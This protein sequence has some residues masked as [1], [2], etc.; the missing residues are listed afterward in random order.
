M[1]F[2][3]MTLRD[4]FAAKAM[5]AMVQATEAKYWSDPKAFS[6]NRASDDCENVAND[7][8]TVADA[9]IEAREQ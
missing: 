4:Y 2:P 3:Q 8:Y 5:Q 1:G 9:M 6:A 7:A